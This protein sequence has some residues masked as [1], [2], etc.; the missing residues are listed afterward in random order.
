MKKKMLLFVGLLLLTFAVSAIDGWKTVEEIAVDG[1][2]VEKETLVF[3]DVMKMINKS[4]NGGNETIID[5]TADK[6]TLINHFDKTYQIIK[7]SKYIEFAEGMLKE[8]VAQ[9]R[10]NPNKVMPKIE[11]KKGENEKL[12]LGEGIEYSVTVDGKQ[13]MH[14][15]VAPKLKDSSLIG[16]REKFAK[17]LPSDLTK[18][19]DIDA[20]IRDHLSTIGLI[21]KHI[22]TPFNSKLPKST[23]T[24]TVMEKITMPAVLFTIPDGYVS[25]DKK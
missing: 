4:K 19:R 10:I 21:I 7:L 5:L 16:F 23:Q 3:G 1:T 20:K 24:M 25:K 14:V 9:G 8:M 17:M 11:Y 12:S 6:I 22:K 18:Y 2:K 15:W 13:Y